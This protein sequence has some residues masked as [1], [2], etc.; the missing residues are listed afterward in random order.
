MRRKPR[1]THGVEVTSEGAGNGGG[2]SAIGGCILL[3]FGRRYEGKRGA[4]VETGKK[5]EDGKDDGD[6][7]GRDGTD[8]GD[9]MRWHSAGIR[10]FASLLASISCVVGF[11]Q[12]HLVVSNGS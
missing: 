8:E 5:E 6:D 3:L 1:E 12:W 7:D 9:G 11:W 2:V 10:F 4:Q